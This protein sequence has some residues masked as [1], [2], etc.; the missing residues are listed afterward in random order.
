MVSAQ[1]QFL[2]DVFAVEAGVEGE[3]EVAC[4]ADEK[5]V[6]GQDGTV[7]IGDS[8]AEFA[9]AI[10]RPS[11]RGREQ[12][13]K[14]SVDQGGVDRNTAQMDPPRSAGTPRKYFTAMTGGGCGTG[15]LLL[16]GGRGDHA[17]RI[18]AEC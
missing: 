1:R 18:A 4:L 9:G 6:G 10:L 12:E 15:A 5:T 2:G 7:G 17:R 16:S 14:C 8:E 11:Q 13:K 3:F